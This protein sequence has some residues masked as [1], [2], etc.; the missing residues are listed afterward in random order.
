MPRLSEHIRC[1]KAL[2]GKSN[3]L[4]HQIMD[5]DSIKYG[6]LHR[7][8]TH[9]ADFLKLIEN[10]FGY[11][12]KREAVFHMLQ[13]WGVITKNDYIFKKNKRVKKQ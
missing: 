11:E 1:T 10:V 7:P 3:P 13:D 5:V 2:L 9:N 8:T 12:G 6:S 4:V